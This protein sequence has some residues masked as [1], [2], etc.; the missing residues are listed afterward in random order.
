MTNFNQSITE[1]ENAEANAM[2]MEKAEFKINELANE[3]HYEN[4]PSMATYRRKYTEA[5]LDRFYYSTPGTN[6]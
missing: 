3:L 6:W 4:L 1:Q 2:E 5:E